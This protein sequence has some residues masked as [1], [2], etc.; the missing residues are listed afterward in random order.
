MLFHFNNLCCYSLINVD[1]MLHDILFFIAGLVLIVAGGNYVTN[2]ASAIASRFGISPV[3]IGVTV[4][5]FGSSMPDFVVCLTSTLQHHSSLALGDIMGANIFDILLVTGIIAL[6][7]PITLDANMR[8]RDLPML[9][10]SSLALFVCGDDILIDAAAHNSIDRTDGL[11]LLAFFVIFMTLTLQM[12]RSDAMVSATGGAAT[13]P[14]PSAK[15]AGI[16]SHMW[17]CALI[18]AAGLAAL[19][20]GGNWLVDGASGIALKAGWSEGL[21]GLTIVG[22]GSSVPDLSTSLIAALKRQPGIALGNIVGAC[23][24]NVFFIIGLC[25]SISPL[26]AGSITALDFGTLAAGSVLVWVV[27]LCNRRR[28]IT[29]LGGALFVAA[30]AAYFVKLLLDYLK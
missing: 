30:Y 29:R 20:V 5:A 25:A 21:V 12:S 7:H 19:V 8:R 4:V 14:R 26:D 13:P 6:V 24:F 27:V 15:P 2:A 18:V 16:Y 9:V 11:L 1:I 10:L 28:K 17:V 3:V 23:I 22:I